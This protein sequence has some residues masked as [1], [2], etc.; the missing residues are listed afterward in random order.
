MRTYAFEL[1]A[2]SPQV[3]GAKT[4]SVGECGYLADLAC[5]AKALGSFT[6]ARGVL[7]VGLCRSAK[8]CLHLG[9]GP[10]SSG[11]AAAALQEQPCRP[12]GEWQDVWRKLPGEEEA[13]HLS[14]H[15]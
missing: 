2:G 14:A 9:L 6:K 3:E 12:Y 8:P 13:P 4:G 15:S 7:A 1:N 10:D 11:R 5:H